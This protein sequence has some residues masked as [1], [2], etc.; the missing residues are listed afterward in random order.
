MWVCTLLVFAMA[1][2]GAAT[3]LQAGLPQMIFAGSAGSL[4]DSFAILYAA[5]GSRL[6]HKT[7]DGTGG[8]ARCGSRLPPVRAQGSLSV[9]HVVWT[10]LGSRK[11]RQLDA[12]MKYKTH[13]PQRELPWGCNRHAHGNDR[14]NDLG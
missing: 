14:R 10:A 9:T 7:A 12:P 13:E 4:P 6:D 5:R 8:P 11:P 2:S 3:A 1:A